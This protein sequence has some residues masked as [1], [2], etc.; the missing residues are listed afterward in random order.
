M[1]IQILGITIKPGYKGDYGGFNVTAKASE[2]GS[3]KIDIQ[4]NAELTKSEREAL[5]ELLHQVAMRIEDAAES[6]AANAAL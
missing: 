5:T 2:V 4:L 6:W 1:K 3:S